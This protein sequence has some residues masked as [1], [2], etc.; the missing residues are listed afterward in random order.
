MA[1][2]RP[3]SPVYGRVEIICVWIMVYIKVT[4]SVRLIYLVK[5]LLGKWQLRRPNNNEDIK[6]NLRNIASDVDK[7]MAA[8]LKLFHFPLSL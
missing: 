7:L 3:K 2:I 8:A 4:V 6:M 1:S 5:E